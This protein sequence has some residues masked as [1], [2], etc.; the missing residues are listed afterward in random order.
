MVLYY[1]INFVY[2]GP[3]LLTT[4]SKILL[5]NYNSKLLMNVLFIN[6]NL[7]YSMQTKVSSYS[8]PHTRILNN[9]FLVFFLWEWRNMMSEVKNGRSGRFYPSKHFYYPQESIWGKVCQITNVV[10]YPIF[11]SIKI[12][13]LY[14]L[15]GIQDTKIIKICSCQWASLPYIKLNHVSCHFSKLKILEGWQ[16]HVVQRILMEN[17]YRT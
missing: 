4:F 6:V 8:F 15:S 5:E 7:F 17:R 10:F 13:W 11:N 16:F 3:C 1:Y 2:W 12:F 14:C 9:S